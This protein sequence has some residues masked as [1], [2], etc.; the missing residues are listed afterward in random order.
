MQAKSLLTLMLWLTL[1]GNA[2]CATA[3]SLF[4]G[5]NGRPAV[6]K[7]VTSAYSVYALAIK[8]RGVAGLQKVADP[9]FTLRLDGN[10]YKGKE[11][12]AA[13]EPS[14]KGLQDGVFYVNIPKV[15]LTKNTAVA[16]T[17]ET[18]GRKLDPET[19]VTTTRFWT[20]TWRK[21][22]QGWTLEASDQRPPEIKGPAPIMTH[23]VGSSPD[24]P[25]TINTTVLGT[26][27]GTPPASGPVRD[28]Y[29]P[30]LDALKRHDEAAFRS[31]LTPDF[32]CTDDGKV[33][34]RQASLKL[35]GQIHGLMREYPDYYL[36]VNKF[37]VKPTTA[38]ALVEE[39]FKGTGKDADMS[40]SYYWMQ[41]WVKT[42]Q[43]WRIDNVTR[44][45]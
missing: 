14:L 42:A 29:D 45:G 30:Y 38:A 2:P 33:L 35:V 15:T 32:T 41:H 16:L 1:A 27:L 44:A 22:P 21:T 20:Q 36:T 25:L 8:Q 40:G 34:S 5:N 6:R 31:L 13:L 12:F 3:A 24:T 26:D 9:N 23:S 28:L 10:T 19:M 11:A 37:F 18:V 4:L 17:V 7:F 39:R 43:G